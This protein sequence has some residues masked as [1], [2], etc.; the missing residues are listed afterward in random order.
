MFIEKLV[1]ENFK[2]FGPGR[3]ILRLDRGMTAFIGANGS[4]KTAACEALL[5]LFGISGQER[6]VRVDDFHVPAG[7]TDLPASRELTI[8]AVLAFPELDGSGENDEVGEDDDGDAA[9]DAEHQQAGVSRAVPEFFRRMAATEDGDLKVR[10]ALRAEWVDD[11]TVEGAITESRVIVNTLVEEYGEDDY[12]Q[13]T[14]A[15]RSRI[16]MIYI[17]A[18]RDGVRQ[19]T[20]FLRSRLWRA[21]Q[22]STGLRDLVSGHAAEVAQN[23][24]EE[25]V[26]QAVEG[27]LTARW[28]ELH[29]AGMHSD[30]KL[31][32]LDG[33]FNQLVRDSELVF[34]PDHNGRPR[35]ARMLSDG[36]RSLLHLAL[37]AAAI[38]VEAAVCAGQHS[39]DFT[40]QAAQLPHLTLIAVEEPENSLSP[41]FLSRIVGQLQDLSS[42]TATQTILSSHSASVM[43]RIRP[44]DV[45]YFR[46]E[47]ATATA[48]VREITL[49][50][51][52]TEAGKYLREAVRAHPELYFA[53]FVVLGEGD[54]EQ[55]VIPRIAQAHGVQLD[56]SFVAMVPLDGRHTNH[57]WKLLH[58]LDIPHATLLDLDYGK[59]GAG[60]AR[61][62]DACNRL[63]DNGLDPLEDL[64]GYDDVDDIHDGLLLKHI[65]PILEHLRTFAVFYSEPLDLDYAMLCAFENAYRHLEG[66][67]RGPDSTDPTTTVLGEKGTRPRYWNGTR[68]EWL[69]WYRYLFLTRSK[70]STHLR[71]LGRLSDEELRLNAPEVL[72][73]LVEHIRK[74]VAL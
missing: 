10:V 65:R 14:A 63:V 4:G 6:S 47:P 48:S 35:P 73:A 23:F 72:V 66:K 60:P 45:R 16:Q 64:D 46:A 11:G 74:E 50:G 43:P 20:A 58:D 27:A 28:Q 62:R 59:V 36:Q 32:L 54:T 39:D 61:L 44:E 52:T 37:A 1:L 56:P 42:K 71:A 40:L 15:E 38:D 31:R 25:P 49:P 19:V 7:E 13:L 9:E 8:E 57:M 55:L 69:G 22:W 24:T 2:C 12:V 26:V 29:D 68:A 53:K 33:D 41:F 5:R 67:Q 70:P 3:T 51:D 18:S 34:E 30:P 21:A 17:P